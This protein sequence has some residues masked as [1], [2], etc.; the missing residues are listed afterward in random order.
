MLEARQS[1]YRPVVVAGGASLAVFGAAAAVTSP[2]PDVASFVATAILPPLIG[3]LMIG[4][5]WRWTPLLLGATGLLDVEAA[6][7]GY[8]FVNGAS[9]A[10]LLPF[11]GLGLFHPVRNPRAVRVAYITAGMATAT[12]AVLAVFAGPTHS[13]AAVYPPAIAIGLFLTASA[14]ALAFNWR[15]S[16]RLVEAMAVAKNELGV[17][18]STEE[19][20]RR[21]TQRLE[22]VVAAAPLAIV[23]TDRDG[24]VQVWNRAAEQIY[25]APAETSIGR[26][27]ADVTEMGATQYAEF[28]RRIEAGDSIAGL[29]VSRRQSDGRQL[30]LRLFLAPVRDDGGRV[31]GAVSV[32]EDL[33]DRRA[34]EAQ[35]RQS[36]KMETLGQLAGSIAHDFNNLLTAIHGFAEITAAT[37][38]PDHAAAPDILQIRNASDRAAELTARLLAFSRQTQPTS[39]ISDLNP[40]VAGM[41]PILSRLLGPTVDLRIS[42]DPEAGSV[43]IDRAQLEQAVLN[44]AVNARDAMPGGGTIRIATKAESVDDPADGSRRR[45]AVLTVE[46]TGLGMWGCPRAGIRAL[47][48]DQGGR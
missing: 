39:S 4:G 14:L 2:R 33:S 38:G 7:S 25:G 28:Q 29:P 22:A 47:L 6:L 18:E 44:L 9:L 5:A 16:G 8:V 21:T 36:Q 12:G 24:V 43:R 20:L 35:L 11:I 10:I 19:A 13:L 26:N 31:I 42:L 32:I 41:G 17:R 27:V 30:E 3:A 1:W 46:D 48:H 34:L 23:L 37:L 45:H 15:L 40:I